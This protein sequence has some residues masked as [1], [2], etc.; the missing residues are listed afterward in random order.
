M[1]NQLN[2]TKNFKYSCAKIKQY[3]SYQQAKNLIVL[4]KE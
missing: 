1:I 2:K 4:Q 3:R